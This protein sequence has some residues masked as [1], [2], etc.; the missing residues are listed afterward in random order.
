MTISRIDNH[1]G[2]NTYGKPVPAKLD[3]AITGNLKQE[4]GGG[5]KK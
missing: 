1:F 3:L 2:L 5:N 4:L